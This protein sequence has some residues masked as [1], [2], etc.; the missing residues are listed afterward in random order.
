M[1]TF[2]KKFVSV[3]GNGD[4]FEFTGDYTLNAMESDFSCEPKNPTAPLP[5]G[6]D[7][8]SDWRTFF[9]EAGYSQRLDEQDEKAKKLARVPGVEYIIYTC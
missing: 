5:A 7:H 3:C 6:L 1:S 8:I 9:L 2:I 4:A